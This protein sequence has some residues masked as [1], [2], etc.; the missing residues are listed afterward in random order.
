MRV[1]VACEFSGVVRDAFRRRGHDAW[2]CDLLP[3]EDGSSYH[4]CGDVLMCDSGPWDLMIAHPPCTF[5]SRA[6]ARWWK[7]PGRNEEAIRAVKFVLDLWNLPI[8]KIAIENPIGKLNN[9]W[10]YPDQII[11]PHW[12]GDPFTKRTCLWL[13]NLPPLM[14]TMLCG[15][16]VPFLPSNTGGAKRGQKATK[17]QVHGGKA[18]SRT[19]PG[20]AQ[21][22]ADQWGNLNPVAAQ[23]A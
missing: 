15:Y 23:A 21:A 16:A 18:A 4:Y 11:E 5:L 3:A 10:R 14:S 2:S 9:E 13:K 20:I 8:H 22:M 7:K 12:F 19:F 1:L 6:G 17:G